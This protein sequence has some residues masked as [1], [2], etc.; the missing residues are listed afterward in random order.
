MTLLLN[1]MSKTNNTIRKDRQY[2][3]DALKEEGLCED[4]ILALKLNFITVFR[5]S[6]CP[7]H[8][9]L[10]S[11]PLMTSIKSDIHFAPIKLK[12][13]GLN[14]FSIKLT[15]CPFCDEPLKS[16]K[17]KS[18]VAS[19]PDSEGQAISLSKGEMPLSKGEIPTQL[20]GSIDDPCCQTTKTLL[21][22]GMFIM[23]EVEAGEPP[24]LMINNYKKPLKVQS[25]FEEELKGM[26]DLV[27]GI[28]FKFCPFCHKDYFE[29]FPRTD[30]KLYIDTPSY[31]I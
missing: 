19:K 28:A 6:F 20:Q 26:E 15:S 30:E 8:F 5:N 2:D 27:I 18:K 10:E 25:A 31:Y 3:E 7:N 1:K 12:R 9:I 17:V 4:M 21:K 16:K 14:Y 22:L 13:N 29:P 11:D 23:S 24:L